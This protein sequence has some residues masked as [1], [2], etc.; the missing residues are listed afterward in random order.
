MGFWLLPTSRS[1]EPA[2]TCR[3]SC[4]PTPL[5]RSSC[6]TGRHKERAEQRGMEGSGDATTVVQQCGTWL[7]SSR[8]CL[9]SS[10]RVQKHPRHSAWCS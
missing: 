9:C 6:R 7:E 3:S 1:C 10:W 8:V 5:R 2:L 4:R